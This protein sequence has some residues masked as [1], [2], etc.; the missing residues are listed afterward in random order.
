M[1]NP[2]AQNEKRDPGCP[3]GCSRCAG[4][5]RLGEDAPSSLQGWRLSLASAGAF[6]LPPAA[7]LVGILI[8][9]RGAEAQVIGAAAGMAAGV[10]VTRI[11]QRVLR[12]S[13]TEAEAR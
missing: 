3:A 5:S 13:G 9:G 12:R 7:A 10:V 8:A 11:L 4:W 2:Q 1:M 6:L